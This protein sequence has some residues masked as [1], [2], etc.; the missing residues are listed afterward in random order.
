V[1]LMHASR[2]HGRCGVDHGRKVDMVECVDETSLGA[3][4]VQV[5]SRRAEHERR[6]EAT[7]ALNGE[8]ENL[9]SEIFSG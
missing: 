1:N 8:Q 4:E 5:G 7:L 9:P 3:Q 2:D 6:R